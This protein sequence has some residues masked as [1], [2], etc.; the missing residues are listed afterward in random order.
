MWNPDCPVRTYLLIFATLGLL[1]G[2]FYFYWHEQPATVVGSMVGPHPVDPLPTKPLTSNGPFQDGSRPWSK[3]ID[4]R[5]NVSSRYRAR[6][7]LPQKD[8]TVHLIEPEADFYLGNHERLHV[9]GVDGDVVMRTAPKISLDSG[10]GGSS[11]APSRGRLHTV[12]M[13]LIDDA[14]PGGPATELTMNTDNIDFDNDT[15]L[16]TTGGFTAPDGTLIPADQV[17]VKVRGEY[18]FDGRGLTLRWND[19]DDRLELLEIAHGEELKIM[20]PS[21]GIGPGRAGK[22]APVADE[23]AAVSPSAPSPPQATVESGGAP[24]APTPATPA[25]AA[26]AASPATKPVRPPKPV[27]VAT[28]QEDV[29]IT[30]GD[31]SLITADTML[32]HFR[33]K[34]QEAGATTA[35]SAANT[36]AKGQATPSDAAAGVPAPSVA[37]APGGGAP[38]GSAA[39]SPAPPAPAVVDEIPVVVHWTGTL[40]I[41]P[42]PSAPPRPVGMGDAIMQLIGKTHPVSVY[43]GATDDAPASEVQ[44]ASLLYMTADGGAFLSG[45]DQFGQVQI[46]RHALTPVGEDDTPPPTL[47]NADTV[48]YGGPKGQTTLGSNGHA[49]IP[50]AANPGETPSVLDAQWS[51]HA[52]FEFFP[53]GGDQMAIRSAK[54]FGDVKIR[55]PQLDLHSQKL[56]LLFAA[57]RASIG[58]KT[59]TG[60][61]SALTEM[62]AVDHVHCR[63][64]DSAGK[65]QTIDAAAL[66]LHTARGSDDK[67]FARQ[68]D[69]FGDSLAQVHATDGTQDLFCDRVQMMLRPSHKTPAAPSDADAPPAPIAVDT[70]SVELERMDARGHVKVNSKDGSDAASDQLLVAMASDGP[71]V[72]LTGNSLSTVSDVKKNVLSGPTIVM[73]PKEQLAHVIGPGTLRQ[74]GEPASAGKAATRPL[75]VIWSEGADLDGIGNQILLRGK[76]QATMPDPDGTIDTAHCD[77]LHI[78]LMP[79]AVSAT[80]PTAAASHREPTT[81]PGGDMDLLRDKTAKVITLETFDGDSIVDSTLADAKGILRQSELKAPRI[82]YAIGATPDQPAHSLLVPSAGVMLVRDHRPPTPGASR[83][84][85]QSG[86]GTGR[87]ATAFKW[88]R[89]MIYNE[90]ARQSVMNGDVMVVHVSDDAKDLPVQLNSD[91][92]TANFQPAAGKKQTTTQPAEGSPPVELKNVQ[93]DGNVLVNRGPMQ[94]TS[95]RLY[96]EPASHWMTFDGNERNPVTVIGDKGTETGDEVRW[97]T[98]TWDFAIKRGQGRE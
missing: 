61:Q 72:M 9:T 94:I 25:S 56:T 44:C 96:F 77:R 12:T 32:M 75:L 2:V 54:L 13:T 59:P 48:D 27:Y 66:D 18:E 93:A 29:R 73:Q 1:G 40:V 62:Q 43:R 88:T 28:F 11:G 41:V 71:H 83:E 26:I 33:L 58:S 5:G 20:H 69:A 16:I 39:P 70:S 76:V 63:L 80:Q 30:Q 6:E 97:N 60:T 74:V 19:R 79:K 10:G 14:A 85:D 84:E 47:V 51:D 31:Q 92:L 67:V 3:M 21:G 82:I 98:Q 52:D 24:V 57:P 86:L 42:E 15:F 35:P 87:G 64:S 4:A 81:Q 68:V 46:V 65:K 45:S 22:T 8:G 91:Q 37:A 90:D 23:S 49:V 36:T 17:P 34:E 55:H 53:R 38:G 7:Y 89:Q 95:Q 50:M 78:E